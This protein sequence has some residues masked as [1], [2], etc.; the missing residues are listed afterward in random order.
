MQFEYMARI[1]TDATLEVDDIGNSTIIAYN[2]SG[3]SF[4]LVIRTSLGWTEVFES[5]PYTPD[6]EELPKNVYQAYSRFEF[7]ENKIKK[8]INMFLNDKYRNITQA[9]VVGVGEAKE[10]FVDLGRYL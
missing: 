8:T 10:M 2:D 6:I 3:E 4:A 7:S 9:R 1:L 5:G